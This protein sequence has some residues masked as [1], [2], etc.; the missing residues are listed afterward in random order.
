MRY[1]PSC[2]TALRNGALEIRISPSKG[3]YISRIKKI[4]H[5]TDNAHK[6]KVAIPRTGALQAK[7]NPCCPAN[8]Q[9]TA[10]A[11]NQLVSCGDLFQQHKAADTGDP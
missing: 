3:L 2:A 5:E 6:N 4:A 11:A 7:N 10:K 1:L 8:E 9:K